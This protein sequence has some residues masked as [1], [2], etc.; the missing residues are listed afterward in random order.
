MTNIERMAREA[1]WDVE[2]G[3]I[4]MPYLHGYGDTA[5]ETEFLTKFAALLAEDVI[6]EIDKAIRQIEPNPSD[7]AEVRHY[8]PIVEGAKLARQIIRAK[9]CTPEQD[10]RG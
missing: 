1:G 3:E 6:Q 10:G 4:T 8:S 2:N 5:D 9:Y 7:A